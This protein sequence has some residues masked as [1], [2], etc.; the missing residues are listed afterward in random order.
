MRGPLPPALP[1]IVER[2]QHLAAHR[3]IAQQVSQRLF[4]RQGI[5]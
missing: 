1:M 4:A 5:E 2:R 3:G